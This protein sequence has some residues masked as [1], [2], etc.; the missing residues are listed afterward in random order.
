MDDF[1]LLKFTDACQC[2][3]KILQEVLGTTQVGIGLPLKHFLYSAVDETLQKIIPTGIVSHLLDYHKW[4]L[5][6]DGIDFS[7][8]SE[9]KVLTLNDLSFGFVMWLIACGLSAC[10]YLFEIF[11]F[12]MRKRLRVVIGIF[13]FL[14]VLQQRLSRKY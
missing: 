3:P 10:G 12:K 14:N 1:M 11:V 9:P 8:V 7:D 6:R 13:L 5:Y 4:V 2:Q